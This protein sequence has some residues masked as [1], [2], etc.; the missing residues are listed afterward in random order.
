MLAREYTDLLLLGYHQ[1]LRPGKNLLHFSATKASRT[2][3]DVLRDECKKCLCPATRILAAELRRSG[4][5]RSF[6]VALLQ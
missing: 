1:E 6:D 2:L 3:P 5:S 4:A